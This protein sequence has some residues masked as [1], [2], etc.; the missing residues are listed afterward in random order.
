MSD[1]GPGLAPEI[2]VDPTDPFRTTRRDRNVGLGLALLR[3]AAEQTAGRVEIRNGSHGGVQLR[4]TVNLAHIDAKPL[5]DLPA[6]FTAAIL[7][8]PNLD[9]VVSLGPD[10]REVLNTLEMKKELDGVPVTHLAVQRFLQE[11]LNEGLREL[12]E[13]AGRVMAANGE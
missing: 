10:G 8:W 4:A 7:A 12:M 1:N 2:R 5:G 6:A 11:Q 9:L 13:W 3:A